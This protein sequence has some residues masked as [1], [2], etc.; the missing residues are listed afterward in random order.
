MGYFFA[1]SGGISGPGLPSC[2]RLIASSFNGRTFGHSTAYDASFGIP[3][4]RT[5]CLL[6]AAAILLAACASDPNVRVGG[7]GDSRNTAGK[8]GI[9]WHF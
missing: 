4:M 8:A 9:G 3:A 5:I 2:R 7:Q 6:I 1:S